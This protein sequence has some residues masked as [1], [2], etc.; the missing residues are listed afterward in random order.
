MSEPRRYEFK[1]LSASVAREA[2]SCG[3]DEIDRWFRKKALEFHDSC[4]GRVITV[5]HPS[6][7]DGQAAQ[8]PVAFFAFA[9]APQPES[10][11]DKSHRFRRYVVQPH[12]CFL[13]LEI[14]Y[15]AVRASRQ[16]RNIGRLIMGWLVQHFID[17]IDRFA[18]PV[19]TLNAINERAEK[20]YREFGFQKYGDQASRRLM[21][22][23][24]DALA[25]RS[26]DEQHSS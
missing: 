15:I 9:I 17:A 21:L 14:Q 16:N 3:D 25:L 23:W 20:L 8:H 18:I 7:E 22:P 1:P 24:Q 10:H 6:S 13:S 11:L 4:K 26:P 12:R 5:H 19:M 2:F